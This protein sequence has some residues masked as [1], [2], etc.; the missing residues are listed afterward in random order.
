MNNAKEQQTRGRRLASAPAHR[1]R[2]KIGSLC[3]A[4]TAAAS[5]EQSARQE[6]VTKIAARIDV[7][8]GNAL[9]IRG[10]GAG[11][12][13]EKGQP[14]QCI[15]RSTWLWS[16]SQCSEPL[17]YKLLLNDQLWCSGE[18]RIAAPGTQA[19]IVPLF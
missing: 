15:E 5:G 13:W 7:G 16:T 6:P 17:T 10:Q 18:N 12:S 19:E 14:L 4:P 2:Q 3:A 9:F 8:F 11:L 1:G